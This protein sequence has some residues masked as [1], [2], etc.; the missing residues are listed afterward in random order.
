MNGMG[1]SADDNHHAWMTAQE[2]LNCT[3]GSTE[4]G[5]LM[6]ACRSPLMTILAMDHLG[7]SHQFQPHPHP[8]AQDKPGE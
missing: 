4:Q 6:Q 1:I 2:L 8:R 5:G 3:K 7:S